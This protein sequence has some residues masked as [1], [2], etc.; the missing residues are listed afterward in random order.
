MVDWPTIAIGDIF[1]IGSGKTMTSKARDGAEPTPFLR[2]SNVFWDRID[3]S[4]VDEMPM[5]PW[6]RK[7]KAL[8]PGDLLVCEGGEIGRAA[9]WEGQAE[10]ISFQNHLHR[11][12]RKRDD[13]DPGFFAYYLQSAFT[14]LG[15]YEGAGNKTTIPNLSRNRL[16]ALD[17]PLPSYD[18]QC[19]IR[20]V[21]KRA[22]A[23]MDL[24]N[25]SIRVAA[26]LRRAAMDDL[27]TRGLR[28]E[29]QK[30]S[31]IGPVPES[32]EVQPVAEVVL[33]FRFARE[34]QL[35]TNQYRQTGKWPI[36]DQGQKRIA[37]FTDDVD[38]VLFPTAPIIVFGDHTRILKFIDHPFAFGA[39]GTK[40]LVAQDGWVP[41]YLF[42]AL[43]NLDI[44]SRGYNRHYRQLAESII[45]KPE[46]EEQLEIAKSLDSIDDKI[47]LHTRK[48]T[49][50]EE[51]FCAL[52]HKLM[53]GE[54]RVTDLDL[55]ALETAA[56]EVAT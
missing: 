4:K 22:R 49:V 21:L 51:L 27:F 7:D 34:K 40:P 9:V 37:G 5:Q 52:L 18:E 25:H 14:Q 53:T 56:T 8:L 15:I 42:H 6:E 50:L 19:R 16:A 31:D 39:D 1:E 46:K 48:R 2:T 17:V 20:S 36:I 35:Q 12:R 45:A 3:L 30:D 55:S 10:G 44:P 28:G 47:D 32:W 43:R 23:A 38:A 11:L 33:P 54:I 41:R 29:S 24:A 26:E 13:V